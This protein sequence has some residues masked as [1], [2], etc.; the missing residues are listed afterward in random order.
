MKEIDYDSKEAQDRMRKE[1]EDLIRACKAVDVK[2][3]KKGVH[4]LTNEDVVRMLEPLLGPAFYPSGDPRIEV[5]FF[6]HHLPAELHDQGHVFG[7]RLRVKGR[8]F[9]EV[10]WYGNT[11][12]ARRGLLREAILHFVVVPI[13][14]CKRER[15]HPDIRAP[16]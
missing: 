10:G 2:Y 9:L 3:A 7:A 11:A 5:R 4:N 16:F 8:R 14:A 15:L 1:D 12:E 13:D 6:R